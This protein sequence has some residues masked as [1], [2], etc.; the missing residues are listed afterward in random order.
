[1]PSPRPQDSEKK[2]HTFKDFGGVNTQASRQ[3]I[4]DDEF[5]WL[6]NI[7]PIGHGHAKVVPGPTEVAT[8]IISGNCYYMTSANIANVDYMFMFSSDG[9]A[10][11]V[12]LTTYAVVQVANVGKFSGIGTQACQW[13]NERIL[14][15]DSN[16]YYSW[17]TSTLTNLAG[18]LLTVDLTQ[19]GSGFTS[20]PTVS[21]GGPGAGAAA[22]AIVGLVASSIHTAGTGYFV[23][24]VLSV[25]GGTQTA[26]AQV[27]VSAVGAGG[28]V[29][30][31]TFASYGNYT[32]MP[33]TSNIATTGGFGTGCTLDCVWGLAG[34]DVTAGGNG[35][36]TAPTVTISGGTNAAA[37][38]VVSIVPTGGTSI[39][40][41]AGRV[42]VAT[43][44]TVVFSA[45]NTYQ[46]FS[47]ANAGGSFIATDET[48][49]SNINRL[50]VGN[51]FLYIMGDTSINVIGD[52]RVNNGITVF[53]NTNV[54]SNIGTTFP[55]S[56]IPYF[57]SE[58]FANRYGI[59]A[60]YGST[61]Q[62]ASD[63]LDGLFPNLD[64][65]YGISGAQ[66]ILYN[67]L[68]L[69]FLALYEDPEAGRRALLLVYA[70][71]KWFFASQGQGITFIAGAPIN[72]TPSLYG[73]DGKSLFKLF[74]D[75]S[76]NSVV[77]HKLQTTLW[78]MED[79]LRVKQVLKL[80]VEAT[81]LVGSSAIGISIDS[82]YAYQ[83]GTINLGNTVQWVNNSGAFVS[84][85]NNIGAP[86][87][88]G[89]SGYS[90]SKFDSSNYGNY[91]GLT[92]TSNS[93][94]IDY[95]GFH[96]QY[97]MRATWANPGT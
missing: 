58:W 15:I 84:W 68:C 79:P 49:H 69:C 40:S 72:G 86:V 6:E 64:L 34:I 32:V 80:G 18:T 66:F 37:T 23:G 2:N 8:S 88:W 54:S 25:A 10:Y 81:T 60:L 22:T 57:R 9:S 71:K 52:V 78:D 33:G 5:S 62:K 4:K 95:S 41:Y 56:V 11:Q 35:Y 21:F 83:T 61:T 96:M 3:A 91:V 43:G 31:L 16:G 75:E 70:N 39:A 76:T 44:R 42:W 24:D 55:P 48:L 12:N 74:D 53:S 77:P 29:T 92:L 89:A 47:T 26:K 20:V 45:P 27:S 30:G 7:I 36:T 28:S 67:I 50:S 94:Q 65:S 14:I 85:I 1:M 93:P 97:E 51:N 73:T 17:D 13:K 46:D 19:Y 82:E 87:A 63:A 59:Y 90:F 38:A